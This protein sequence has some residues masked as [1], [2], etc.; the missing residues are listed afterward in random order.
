[1]EK[2]LTIQ[3]VIE[4]NDR[5]KLYNQAIIMTIKILLALLA[6]FVLYYVIGFVRTFMLHLKLQRL[7]EFYQNEFRYYVETTD[8]WQTLSHDESD[9]KGCI[10]IIPQ[11]AVSSM[12][13]TISSMKV[14]SERMTR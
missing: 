10:K 6:I 12:Y 14:P 5:L 2:E 11:P 3:R 8:G 9:G 1:M 13:Y 7:A 4:N